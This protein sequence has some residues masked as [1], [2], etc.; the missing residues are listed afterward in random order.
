MSSSACSF[1]GDVDRHF[2][3]RLSPE[4]EHSLRNH[5]PDCELCRRRY[6]RQLL[7]AKLDPSAKKPEE[8]LASGLGL[9]ASPRRFSAVFVPLGGLAAAALSLMLVVQLQGRDEAGFA[10]RGAPLSGSELIVHRATRTGA[11]EPVE[12][13][14]HADDELAFAYRNEGGSRFLMA[15]GVDEHRHVYWYYPTWL[16]PEEDP[17][18]IT[19]SKVSASKELPEAIRHALDGQRLTVYGLFLEEPMT[20][21]AIEALVQDE[22]QRLEG[23]PG[24]KLW[25]SELKVIR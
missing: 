2:A 12:A 10:P 20:V 24:A 16:D 19:I 3:L 1:S 11:L 21:S 15:F 23:L 5:L 9:R 22:P 8:R 4:K 7:L 6:D 14:I 13:T 25:K 18:A 17:T